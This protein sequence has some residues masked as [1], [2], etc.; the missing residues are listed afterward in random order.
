M[1]TSHDVALV[2]DAMSGKV[3]VVTGAN[4][5]LG[6]DTCKTLAKQGCSKVILLCRNEG[7]AKEAIELLKHEASKSGTVFEYIHFDGSDNASSRYAAQALKDRNEK[8]DCI[9]LNAGGMGGRGV[10]K[11]TS[12][13]CTEQMAMNV[14]GHALLTEEMLRHST[15]SAGARIVYATSE[16]AVGMGPF[17]KPEFPHGEDSVAKHLNS[18]FTGKPLKWMGPGYMGVSGYGCSKAIGSMYFCHL[19]TLHPELYISS[20]SPGAT[21]GTAAMKESPGWFV[22][23]AK[24]LAAVMMHGLQKGTAR[25]VDALTAHDYPQR[26]PSGAVVMSFD[27]EKATGKVCNYALEDTKKKKNVTAHFQD[28]ELH[29]GAY[30]AVQKHFE[31]SA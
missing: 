14:V 7:R 9:L 13:G 6:L 20:V 2:T 16:S 8:V 28:K 23:I 22:C 19:A 29:A 3:V 15:L 18:T 27:N 26:F 5:G 1:S 17:P 4:S 10:S 12:A 24:T 31:A 30:R 11:L 25:Y 21:S